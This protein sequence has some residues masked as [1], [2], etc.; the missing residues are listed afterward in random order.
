MLHTRE[1]MVRKS[2]EIGE[3]EDFGFGKRENKR[4]L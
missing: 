2:M 1:E 3:T 4:P